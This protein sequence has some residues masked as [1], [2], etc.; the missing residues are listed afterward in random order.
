DDLAEQVCGSGGTRPGQQV[1]VRLGQCSLEIGALELDG[2]GVQDGLGEFIEM[3][4][5]SQDGLQMFPA[6]AGRGYVRHG[7]RQEPRLKGPLRARADDGRAKAD[8]GDV[9]FTDAPY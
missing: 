7:D 6:P 4:L 3:A 9:S 5:V 1:A 2:E 8:R